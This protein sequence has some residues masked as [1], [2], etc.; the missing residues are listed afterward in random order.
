MQHAAGNRQSRVAMESVEQAPNG[1]DPDVRSH[2][3]QVERTGQSTVAGR[4]VHEIL[5]GYRLDWYE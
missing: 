2:G 5:G 4:S 1:A 3:E